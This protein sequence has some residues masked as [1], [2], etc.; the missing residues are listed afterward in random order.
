MDKKGTIT[1]YGTSW[2]GACFRSQM[3]LDQNNIPFDYINIDEVPEAAEFV[4]KVNNGMRSVPTII[5]P[6]GKILV[7]PTSLELTDALSTLSA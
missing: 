4:L 1:L 5:M 2:C 3:V 7:E 6:D